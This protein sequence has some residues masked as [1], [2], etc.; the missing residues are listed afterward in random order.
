MARPDVIDRSRSFQRLRPAGIPRVA[1]V[2]VAALAAVLFHAPAAPAQEG[3]IKATH[4][5]WQ[6][7]CGQPPGASRERC[8]LVQSVID[9]ERPSIGLTVIFLKSADSEKRVL[10][11]VAPLGILLPAGLGLRIDDEK[12]GKAPF[13]RCRQVGCIAEVAADDALMD[14]LKTGKTAMFVVFQ[15]PEEGIAIPVSLAGFTEALGSLDSV[16][17]LN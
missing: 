7:N 10:R 14:K 5:S 15:T 16:A 17:S 4:G 2:L 1:G 6:V 11:V 8:A 13:V 12:I 3:E 9:E